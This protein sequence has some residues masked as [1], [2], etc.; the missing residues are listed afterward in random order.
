MNSA[1]EKCIYEW[2]PKHQGF[3]LLLESSW[4]VVQECCVQCRMF[5]LFSMLCRGVEFNVP[6]TEQASKHCWD[7]SPVKEPPSRQLGQVLSF[8]QLHVLI[9][10]F[11]CAVPRHMFLLGCLSSS[12]CH[13]SSHAVCAA[14]CLQCSG[15]QGQ[16]NSTW[17][18]VQVIPCSAHRPV[19]CGSWALG[20]DAEFVSKWVS[21]SCLVLLCSFEL[22][23]LPGAAAGAAQE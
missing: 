19:P 14:P 4:S 22:C 1:K 2:T 16:R 8:R 3:H 13:C 6:W 11:C 7:T 9:H 20:Q 10:L 15:A 5:S 12:L 23:S 18:W 21:F 17:L